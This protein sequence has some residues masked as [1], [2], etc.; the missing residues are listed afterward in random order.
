MAKGTK[1][2][3]G[4]GTD[5]GR[6]KSAAQ[7]KRRAR[8]GSKQGQCDPRPQ[9]AA[10]DYPA[11]QYGAHEVS[12]GRGSVSPT[13]V[14][15]M[16]P[17]KQFSRRSFGKLALSPLAAKLIARATLPVGLQLF[18]VREQCEK[19]L[20]AVLATLGK[21]G[22]QG[23]EFAGFYGRSATDI[24]QMLDD[25]SL[26]CCGS[27][28]PLHQLS[29]GMFDQTVEFNRILGNRILIVP[30]LPTQYHSSDGWKTAAELFNKLSSRLSPLGMRIG[31]HNHALEFHPDE[32]GHLPWHIFF[33][34]TVPEVIMQLDLGNACLAGVDPN[35][36]LRPY[37]GRAKS[38]HVKDC[39]PGQPDVMLGTSNFDWAAFLR[40]CQSTAGTEWYIIEHESHDVPAMQG[41]K[42]SLQQFQQILTRS[43]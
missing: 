38:V 33:S 43:A 9:K 23:V 5:Q 24:R 32:D 15:K 30:G 37:P 29:A 40:I 3:H 27:H 8:K 20:P 26:Q 6:F 19:D 18:S 13:S 25:A 35:T 39:L 14:K 1:T 28:T 42:Q 36:L 2:T 12:V 22:Y 41:A 31:Y 21:F 16:G 17:L 10:Y 7:R 11:I 34:N 4:I